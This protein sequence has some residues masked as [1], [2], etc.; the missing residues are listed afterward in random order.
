MYTFIIH[1]T[2]FRNEKNGCEGSMMFKD[3][4]E[5]A[6]WPVQLVHVV[7]FL[8]QFCLSGSHFVL[9]LTLHREC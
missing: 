6:I 8:S 5:G 1:T 3:A 9:V 4:T 7:I 2:I